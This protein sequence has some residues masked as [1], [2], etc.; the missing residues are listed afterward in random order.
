MPLVLV[1]GWNGSHCWDYDQTERFTIGVT[2]LWCYVFA[3]FRDTGAELVAC[4]PVK[5]APFSVAGLVS[6]L[7]LRFPPIS[8]PGKGGWL[9]PPCV[10]PS[11]LKLDR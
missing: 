1:A 7:S 9:S 11:Y 6:W 10:S 2:H 5:A 8:V 4:V 3:R